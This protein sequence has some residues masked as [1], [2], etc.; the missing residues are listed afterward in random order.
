MK[1]EEKQKLWWA[2][3][4]LLIF[5]VFLAPLFSFNS[6]EYIGHLLQTYPYLAPLIVIGVRF[7]TIVIAPLPGIPVSFA[8]IAFL[9]WQEAWLYNLV[10]VEA[11]SICAFFIARRFREPVV[12]WFTPLRQVHEW[13]KTVSRRMQ[14]WAFIGLRFFAGFPFFFRKNPAP[15]YSF[16]FPFFLI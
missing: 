3:G 10:A 9:P 1:K 11:G 4:G 7:L 8:S 15:P 2:L 13:Q 16:S 6:R 5:I 12:A 14:L